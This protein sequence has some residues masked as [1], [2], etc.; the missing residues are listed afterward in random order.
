MKPK[1]QKIMIVLSVVLFVLL[2][3]ELLFLF[4]Y[5]QSSNVMEK[6]SDSTAKVVGTSGLYI[7]ATDEDTKKVFDGIDSYM[8]G[9]KPL[10]KTGVLKELSVNET[11]K[12]V[13]TN[14]GRVNVARKTANGTEYKYT[15]TLSISN[16]ESTE[17]KEL[18][19][20]FTENEL[21]RIEVFQAIGNEGVEIPLEDLEVGDFVTINT[22]MNFLDNT[23]NSLISM[24]IVKLL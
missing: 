13:I 12:S 21:E 20:L 6:K 3:G 11:F 1:T 8:N 15:F 18:R 14:I 22:V 7:K 19:Y 5:K 16:P 9:I 2:V 24:K 23:S 4:F 17:R 10:Y